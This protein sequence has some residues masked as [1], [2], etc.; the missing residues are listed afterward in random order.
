M[1]SPLRGLTGMASIALAAC[2]TE[3]TP[4][5]SPSPLPGAGPAVGRDAVESLVV[6]P[7]RF[8]PPEAERFTL[9]GGVPVFFI[10]DHSLP[11]VEVFAQ[12]RGG[13]AYFDRSDL[14]VATA[15]GSLLLSGGTA[16]LPP[17]SVDELIE[18]YALTPSFGTGGA[19]S[20]TSIGSLTRHVDT[21]LA[22]WADMLRRPRFDRE[23]VDVWRAR[24]LDSVRRMRDLPNSVAIA[25]FNRIMFGDHPIGWIMEEADLAPAL[26]SEER[27]RRVHR[28]I[29]CPE[30]MIL[31]ITGDITREEA[32]RK[33]EAVFGDWP[34]C[35]RK[36]VAPP[37]PKIRTGGGVFVIHKD[38][39]QSTVLMGQPGGVLQRND[40]EFFASQIAN[41]ILGGGGFSSRLMSRLRT[42]EGLAYTA[43]TAWTTG[44]RHERVFG[45]FTQTKGETT[46]AAARQIRGVLEEF[47]RAPPSPEEVRLAV[48]NIVNGFVFAF[49]DPADVV[50]RQM[51]YRAG[52]LPEDWL[53][54]YLAGAQAVNPAAV[55]D[56]VR[57]HIRPD[58][59]TIVI[60]GDT[61][62]FEA[63]PSVLGP[64]RSR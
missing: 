2:A 13:S 64:L 23:R 12:F 19:S 63:P 37:V 3:P 24:E 18:F 6:P 50:A 41:W 56:V 30:N 49:E 22:L 42:E 15:L 61:T 17:D 10:E 5:R 39:E 14:A 60:V 32:E 47:R 44:T 25:E 7:L 57:R 1:R 20:F 55:H 52:G 36:L 59:L 46:I 54:L 43:W 58:D 38:L 21:A 53:E 4:P 35:P 27:L 34:S 29:F 11:L 51:A 9:S 33:L 48:D 45:A 62:R 8:H 16:T 28:E 31:G 40:P 26:L